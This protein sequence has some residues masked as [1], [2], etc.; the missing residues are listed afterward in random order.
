MT[1]WVS[2]IDA[3]VCLR[4]SVDGVLERIA[5]G[6]L[7]AVTDA[8][9]AHWIAFEG[10]ALPPAHTRDTGPADTAPGQE[11]REIDGT[12]AFRDRLRALHAR[13]LVELADLQARHDAEREQ[14]WM[15]YREEKERL[16]ARYRSAGSGPGNPA[17]GGQFP[18][19]V[20]RS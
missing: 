8:D 18:R 13:H 3:A 11:S 2:V 5:E 12:D 16:L 1:H 20:I 9:G 14:A 19:L 7:V 10:E 17:A 6:S 15:T 4:T